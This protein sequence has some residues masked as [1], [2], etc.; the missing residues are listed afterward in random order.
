MNNSYYKGGNG[1]DNMY[2]YHQN[3]YNVFGGYNP[4]VEKQAESLRKLGMK[5]GAAM[6]GCTLLQYLVSYALVLTGL[7]DAVFNDPV[8]N[9]GVNSIAQIIY[10]VSPF[11]VLLLTLGE[12]KHRVF[13]IYEKPRKFGPFLLAILSGLMICFAGDLISSYVTA[14]SKLLGTTFYN[15]DMAIPTDLPGIFLFTIG[16]AVLPALVE[17]FAFRG[18][19]LTS[20]RKYGD[21]FAIVSSALLFAVLHGNMIQIPFAFIAGLALGY[22]RIATGSVWTSVII[23]FLNNMIAVVFSVYYAVN[24]QATTI[25][26]FICTAAIFVVGIAATALW[27]I[28]DRK[29]LK[30]CRMEITSRT[31][32]DVFLTVPTVIACFFIAV[33]S[34]VSQSKIT[35]GFGIFPLITVLILISVL[36]MSMI[37]RIARDA[38]IKYHSV[39]TVSKVII[40]LAD[41]FIIIGIF[42]VRFGTI[43]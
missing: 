32:Y 12:E 14:L 18:V 11:A 30:P 19:V 13:E 25:P 33:S 26:Y 34:S 37:K 10:I 1:N 38:R 35:G 9:W 8:M 27:I 2:G 43:S 31:A 36:L 29:K 16:C 15:A 6:L 21:K 4:I 41:I 39:Y 40:V 22:F 28:S 17:E 42:T 23:H 24:P 20:L 3:M 5:I 7:Y